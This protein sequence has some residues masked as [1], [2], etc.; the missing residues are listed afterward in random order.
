MI[1]NIMLFVPAKARM[2]FI[3]DTTSCAECALRRRLTYS[4]PIG[5]KPPSKRLASIGSE[6]VSLRLKAHSAHDVESP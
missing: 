2:Q 1:L 5:A 3:K 4:E 6:Y